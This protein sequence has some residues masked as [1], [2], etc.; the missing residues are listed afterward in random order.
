MIELDDITISLP[1]GNPHAKKILES[2]TLAV[3]AGEWV[4]VA[5]PNGSGKSTLLRAV[6][7]LYP[8]VSGSVRVGAPRARAP[9]G[10]GANAVVSLLLQE[11]DNQ[12]VASSVRNELLLCVDPSVD[13]GARERRIADAVERFSLGALLERNPHRISGGEKQRLALATAWLAGP[14]VLLLDEPASYLDPA[15]RERCVG[16]VREL[17]RAG[18]TILWATPAEEDIREASRVVYVSEGRV[19]FDGP[20]REFLA[21]AGEGGFDV[22]PSG[23]MSPAARE[24]SALGG[25]GSPRPA[26]PSLG[27]TVISMEELSFAYGETDVF[28]G[29]SG[30]ILEFE[31]VGIA[32]NNG[33]GK[34]TLL[35]LFGGVLEPT[36]GK[37]Q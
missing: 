7:G 5:G 22:V 36:G 21:A 20:V 32:G 28:R 27:D 30:Q 6:A 12:F 18:V 11:P 33:S 19:R 14:D 37:I 8:P 17:H 3:S 31:T 4:A 13:D 1:A 34:S 35:S 9:G 10:R 2:V 29:A 26:G 15:E 23:G 24:I 16:F 25:D